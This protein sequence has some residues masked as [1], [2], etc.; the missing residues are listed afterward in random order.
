[1]PSR[2]SV[3]IMP[4]SPFS[5]GASTGGRLRIS[6]VSRSIVLD[7]GLG[8]RNGFIGACLVFE[9]RGVFVIGRVEFVQPG[10]F[11]LAQRCGLRGK[12][13]QACDRFMADVAFERRLDPGK[14][15]LGGKRRGLLRHFRS[16]ESFEQ[17]NVGPGFAL[18]VVEELALDA[19]AGGEIGI[20]PDEPR[21]RIAAANRAGEHHAPHAVGIGSV[22]ARW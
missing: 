8:R 18:F 5:S 17:G 7:R 13:D 11:G 12:P 21:A 2:D 3:R 14:A 19:A 20:A 6:W 9:D 10:K 16:C 4:A 22:A 15:L 1:M